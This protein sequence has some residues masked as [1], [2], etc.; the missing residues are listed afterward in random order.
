MPILRICNETEDAGTFHTQRMVNV[1]LLSG[2]TDP[3]PDQGQSLK[4]SQRHFFV[5]NT[6]VVALNFGKIQVI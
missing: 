2:V 3:D 6:P 1:T 5:V 4:K